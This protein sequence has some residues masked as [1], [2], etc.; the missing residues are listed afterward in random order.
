[1]HQFFIGEIANLNHNG[2]EIYFS[3]NIFFK[4]EDLSKTEFW[5]R[6]FRIF[7]LVS[8]LSGFFAFTYI[9]TVRYV[10]EETQVSI[11]IERHVKD[12]SSVY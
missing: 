10:N 11:S 4:R 5:I 9:N 12:Y 7:I 3:R 6:N 2:I 8:C 1:M